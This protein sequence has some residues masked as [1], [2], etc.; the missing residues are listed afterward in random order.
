LA[1]SDEAA[2]RLG[3]TQFEEAA[4]T[5]LTINP[6]EETARELL[7]HRLS[8]VR[9]RVILDCLARSDE[10]WARSTLE[11]E[12]P[13]ALAYQVNYARQIPTPRQ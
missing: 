3:P 9:G 5:L 13:Y 2:E 11:H 7:R 4:K 8:L 10:A 1:L 6:R 12:A